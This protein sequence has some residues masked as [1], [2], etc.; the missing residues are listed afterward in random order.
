MSFTPATAVEICAT[1]CRMTAVSPLMTTAAATISG[2]EEFATMN[3]ARS[4][5]ECAALAATLAL[6]A[7]SLVA[8]QPAVRTAR[9]IAL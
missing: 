5:I 9:I 4:E 2:C 8:E 3:D 1:S 7:I 6:E